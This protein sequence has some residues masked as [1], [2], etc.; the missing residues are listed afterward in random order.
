MRL[1]MEISGGAFSLGAW[2]PK[3]PCRKKQ[4]SNNIKMYNHKNNNDMRQIF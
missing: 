4:K 2:D 3:F 1:E